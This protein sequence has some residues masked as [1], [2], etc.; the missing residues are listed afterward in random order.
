MI[1]TDILVDGGIYKGYLKADGSFVVASVPPG[2]HLIEIASPNYG[3]ERYR[4]DIT[5]GGK[6]RA[7][8]ANFLQPSKVQVVPYPLRF[9]A[10]KQA[11]FFEIREQWKVTDFLFNPMV[12]IVYPFFCCK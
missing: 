4:V 9:V 2:S 5:K 7:R 3:F 8:H 11:A 10:R 12:I 6:I 1:D